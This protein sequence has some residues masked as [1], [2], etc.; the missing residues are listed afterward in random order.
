MSNLTF[1]DR[2]L[3]FYRTRP[4]A[5][6]GVLVLMAAVGALVGMFL[7]VSI[8][9]H[10]QEAKNPFFKVVELTDETDDPAIWGKNFPL[11]YDDYRRTVDMV[12]TKYG[13]SDAMPHTP[14]ANDPRTVVSQSKIEEDPRYPRF[15]LTIKGAGYKL[16]I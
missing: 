5:V 9:E 7:L 16:A 1:K 10:K 6:F 3:N 15:L 14:T 13:G 8:F 11:Q 2:V 4:L 12:H